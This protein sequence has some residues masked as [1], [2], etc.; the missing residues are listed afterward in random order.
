LLEERGEIPRRHVRLRSPVDGRF[1]L[2]DPTAEQNRRGT[3]RTMSNYHHQAQDMYHDN[4]TSRS[5][6][7]HRHPPQQLHRQPSRQFDAYGSMPAAIYPDDFAARYEAGLPERMNPALPSGGYG[8]DMNA[9]QTWNSN[10]LGG[11]H[12]LGNIGS[13]GQSASTR[14]KPNARTRTGLPSVRCLVS[15]AVCLTAQVHRRHCPFSPNV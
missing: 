3:S 2:A 11:T 8:Y 9:A 4:S 10:G 12:P 15:F 7:S 13:M 5:P 14:M 6:G 1:N